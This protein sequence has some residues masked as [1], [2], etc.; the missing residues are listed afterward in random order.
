MNR[1]DVGW[2]TGRSNSFL[3]LNSQ[4]KDLLNTVKINSN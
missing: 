3:S 2:I 1:H 4:E